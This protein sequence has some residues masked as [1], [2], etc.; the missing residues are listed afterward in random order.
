MRTAWRTS[1]VVTGLV[2]LAAPA[3]AQGRDS[4]PWSVT[5]EMGTERPVWGDAYGS[6]V[7][8][9]GGFPIQVMSRGYGDLFGFGVNWAG[10]LA[11]Q[12]TPSQE[13]RVRV[14][15]SRF[16]GRERS[17][18]LR[19]AGPE[20]QTL[21]NRLDGDASAG[22]DVGIRHYL[23]R[24]N[25]VRPYMGVY[26]GVHRVGEIRAEFFDRAN[27]FR[28]TSVRMYEASTVPT[29]AAGGGVLVPLTTRIDVQGALELRWRGTLTAADGL[30]NT[31]LEPI[32]NAN[33]RWSLPASIGARIGF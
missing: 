16:E 5:V 1:V 32:T 23:P 2:L 13:V 6:G 21:F 8:T 12:L 11:Y 7:G 30:A 20:T 4:S 3:G 17:A 26:A 27:I 24:I 18:G 31:G 25:E 22:L 10:S 33:R 14:A 15:G 29:I 28:V 9:V 19:L